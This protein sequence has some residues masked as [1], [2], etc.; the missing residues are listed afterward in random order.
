ML[1]Q[2]P[3]YIDWEPKAFPVSMK[4]GDKLL[5]Y[6]D[7]TVFDPDGIS[8]GYAR[9]TDTLGNRWDIMTSHGT[10]QM[11]RQKKRERF[12]WK[13][14][15]YYYDFISDEMKSNKIDARLILGLVVEF[16]TPRLLMYADS[17]PTG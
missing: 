12:L 3:I 10:I 8:L 5:G 14:Q 16:W 7:G 9:K 4:H 11:D 1:K 17:G 6:I 13:T 15:S 2:A